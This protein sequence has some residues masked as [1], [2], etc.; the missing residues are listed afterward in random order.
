MIRDISDHSREIAALCEK[1]RVVRLEVFGSAARGGFDAATSDIDLIAEFA[2]T[3]E[4]G[5]ADRYMDFA[6]ALEALLGYKVDLLTPP[7][8]RNR[9]FAENIKRDAIL[10]Y[11]ATNPQAA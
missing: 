8:I 6:D 3:R 2:S 7:S 4:P 11:D 10:I 1:Y 5:Y 9:H